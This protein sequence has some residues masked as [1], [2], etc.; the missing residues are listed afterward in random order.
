MKTQKRK[1]K[2]R[3]QP[4]QPNRSQV[5]MERAKRRK[6]EIR[7]RTRRRVIKEA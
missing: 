5:K 4:L 2:K 7:R 3:S 1:W 6:K